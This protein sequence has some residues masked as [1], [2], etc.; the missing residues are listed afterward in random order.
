MLQVFNESS[1][2]AG[3]SSS[4]SAANSSSNIRHHHSPQLHTT[5]SS[6]PSWTSLLTSH[7]ATAAAAASVGA[8]ID[9]KHFDKINKL[10]DKLLKQC[11][12]ERMNLINS[13]P[14]IIDILPD[15]CQVFNTIYVVYENKL[16]ILNEIDYFCLLIKNCLDKFQQLLDL[17]KSAGKRMYDVESAERQQLTKYTLTFSHMLAEMKSLFPKDV[18]EGQNYRITKKDAGDFWKSNFQDRIIVNW[19]EFENKLKRVHHINENEVDSLRDTI[20]LTRSKY[21]SIFEFDV[22][23]RL[24]QPWNNLLD[25]WKVLVINHPGYMAYST[26]DEVHKRLLNVII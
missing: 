12:S 26:Y 15:I 9:K 20:Q 11:Q 16:H 21:V 3:A 10:S 4:T 13:P 5:S 25:N 22:F 17:F 19:K 14:Y 18:Y 2:G 8:K 24:F 1:L 23:T 7:H 6:S